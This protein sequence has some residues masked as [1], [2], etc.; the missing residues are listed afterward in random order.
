MSTVLNSMPLSQI[1]SFNFLRLN[2]DL[3]STETFQTWH[4]SSQWITTQL[5]SVNVIT[6]ISFSFIFSYILQL[7]GINQ[8]RKLLYLRKIAREWNLNGSELFR[9]N[10]LVAF[11]TNSMFF[12]PLNL[13]PFLQQLSIPVNI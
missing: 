10:C 5:R 1:Q 8:S 6:S 2:T 7:V 4:S 9:V 13:G 3:K 12:P 11:K